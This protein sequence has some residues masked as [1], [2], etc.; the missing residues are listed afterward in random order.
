[1]KKTVRILYMSIVIT[2]LNGCSN[3]TMGFDEDSVFYSPKKK[4]NISHPT[5]KIS[6]NTVLHVP[7]VNLEIKGTDTENETSFYYEL[8]DEE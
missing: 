8:D 1:M 5:A 2:L 4:N 7:D 6:T 3:V